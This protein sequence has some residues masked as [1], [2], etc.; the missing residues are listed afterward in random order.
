MEVRN[1]PRHV[2]E[3]ALNGVGFVIGSAVVGWIFVHVNALLG[4]SILIILLLIILRSSR[5]F[6]SRFRDG[7]VDEF[8]R[9]IRS[10]AADE[11]IGSQ[12]RRPGTKNSQ[13]AHRGCGE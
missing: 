6:R 4:L 9:A 1:I 5:N 7:N 13:P 3:G 11:A 2:W 10:S 8:I 12:D